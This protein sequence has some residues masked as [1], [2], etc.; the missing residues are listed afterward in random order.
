MQAVVTGEP[1]L[2]WQVY[3]HYYDKFKQLFVVCARC[4]KTIV[5]KN[6][7]STPLTETSQVASTKTRFEQTSSHGD[8]QCPKQLSADET[9][10]VNESIWQ[11]SLCGL[12]DKALPTYTAEKMV[13]SFVS[14]VC[15]CVCV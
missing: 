6:K 4:Q 9:L 7:S 11:K 15:T 10:K 5:Q 14:N 2:D 3:Q 1:S 12:V 13:N 8:V